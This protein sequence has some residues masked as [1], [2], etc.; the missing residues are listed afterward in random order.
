MWKRVSCHQAPRSNRVDVIYS[1]AFK[2]KGGCHLEM[3]IKVVGIINY[4][5]SEDMREISLKNHCNKYCTKKMESLAAK[6]PTSIV[7]KYRIFANFKSLQLQNRYTKSTNTSNTV[8][9]SVCCLYGRVNI[10]S[11][12]RLSREL[13]IFAAFN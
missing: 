13:F 8:C 10:S 11:I 9:S 1:K 5:D 7:D 2:K 4:T 6:Q 12:R 3:A